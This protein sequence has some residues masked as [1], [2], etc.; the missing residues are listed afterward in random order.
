MV[1]QQVQVRYVAPPVG[2]N[3]V[4]LLKQSR[5]LW[6]FQCGFHALK[7]VYTFITKYIYSVYNVGC[8]PRVAKTVAFWSLRC[9][10]LIAVRA[11][12]DNGLP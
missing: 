10:G 4:G 5:D 2:I 9:N 7:I 11:D 6:L 12:T 8:H 3:Y 1:R